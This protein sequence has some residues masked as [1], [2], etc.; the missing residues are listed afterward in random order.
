LDGARASVLR[1]VYGVAGLCGTV[2]DGSVS[3][4]TVALDDVRYR[5]VAAVA[6]GNF[7]DSRRH[8]GS[9]GS[10][11]SSSDRSAFQ[12]EGH[13]SSDDNSEEGADSDAIGSGSGPDGREDEASAVQFNY[14]NASAPVAE[15]SAKL[16]LEGVGIDFCLAPPPPSASR[17]P[18]ADG[19]GGLSDAPHTP[20]LSLSL[21]AAAFKF[22]RATSGHTQS[23]LE[24]GALRLVDLRPGKRVRTLVAPATDVAVV[25]VPAPSEASSSGAPELDGDDD[26]GA[27]E[28]RAL[29]PRSAPSPALVVHLATRGPA[30]GTSLSVVC[31]DLAVNV[32][33][34]PILCLAHFLKRPSPAA[35][36]AAAPPPLPPPPDLFPPPPT[37]EEPP[38][39]VRRR[40]GVKSAA[41]SRGA[42][43]SEAAAV[44]PPRRY[45]VLLHR[46]RVCLWED[47]AA[48]RSRVLVLRGLAA[49]DGK[50]LTAADARQHGSAATAD[51]SVAATGRR[52]E[53]LSLRVEK[54]ESCI[55]ADGHAASDE[56]SLLEPLSLHV[57]LE[58]ST[59]PLHPPR[60]EVALS[61][62][63][64]A[65]RC[66][67]RDVQATT[68]FL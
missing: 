49:L 38:R 33:Y 41:S 6:A 31:N 56:V 14:G 26:D 62:E 63:P 8:G 45:K 66:S 25:A 55:V 28:A 47:E 58:R 50:I 37:A 18:A 64:I 48:L 15:L 65:V 23:D 11:S 24:V 54:L 44:A 46:L 7:G 36:A 60:R 22:V 39:C 43:T 16:R 27:T 42:A 13:D 57:S 9:V 29:S 4:L 59:Q 68:P 53:A 67:Y 2:A 17:D 61:V 5:V 52:L 51:A 21:D 10:S 35:F 19:D 32:A 30:E 1:D 12:L 34:D 20:S 40:S 3:R